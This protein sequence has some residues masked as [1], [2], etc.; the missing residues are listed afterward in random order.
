MG[1][2]CME[3]V[4]FLTWNIMKVVGFCIYK[5]QHVSLP[6]TYVSRSR[7]ALYP[8]DTSGVVLGHETL[9]D[10]LCPLSKFVEE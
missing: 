2:R 9:R 4:I 6:R 3:K 7:A 5:R 10:T 1:E 8:K